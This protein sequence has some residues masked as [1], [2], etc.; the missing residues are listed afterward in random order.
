MIS[1]HKFLVFCVLSVTTLLIT[2]G[3]NKEYRIQSGDLL[4]KYNSDLYAQVNSMAKDVKPLCEGF[5]LTEYLEAKNFKTDKFRVY[6]ED[7]ESFESQFGKGNKTLLQGRFK[8]DDICL[9]KIIEIRTYESYPGVALFQ[10]SYINCGNKD[11][12]VK[13]W[14]NHHYQVLPGESDPPFWSFQGSSSS[15]RADWI[16]PLTTGFYKKNYMGM[17]DT[18]YGGGIP[19]TDLWRK[20]CGIAIGHTE[21]VPKEVCLPVD[22][23]SN[24]NYTQIGIEKE[25]PEFRDLN[26]GDTLNTLETFVMTH[27]GDYFSALRLFSAIMEKK[28]IVPVKTEDEAFE[29]IWCGWGYMRNFTVQ[30]ILGT[31]PKVKELGIKWA[32]IDDGYQVAEG[33][34]NVNR[35]RFPGGDADMRGLVKAIHGYGLKAKL[36][37]A[38]LAADP[39]SKILKEEPDV[40][41][42]NAMNHQNI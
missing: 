9:D 17:N 26:P 11:V 19:V 21:L 29:P 12:K 32:V 24:T 5:Q 1:S 42:R 28:G 4:I 33:D 3:C 20:D 27:R 13:L 2:G 36:W 16:L 15:E 41:L 30:E 8:K 39:G 18:D 10:V 31:L 38:P 25:F 40:L 35:K 37:W 7:G 14:A 22:F 23:D 6:R 34:W